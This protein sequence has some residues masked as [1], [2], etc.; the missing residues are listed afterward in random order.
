MMSVVQLFAEWFR[1]NKGLQ[2]KGQICP[3]QCL[4]HLAMQGHWETYPYKQMD[5]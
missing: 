2:D 5:I 1:C 4:L 3:Q